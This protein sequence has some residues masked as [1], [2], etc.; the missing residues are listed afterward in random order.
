M[1]LCAKF[2]ISS[3]DSSSFMIFFSIVLVLNEKLFSSLATRSSL[4]KVSK[5]SLFEVPHEGPEVKSRMCRPHPQRDRKRRLNG[6]VCQ[7]HRIKKV[8]PRRC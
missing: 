2:T 4:F 1:A 3:L 8:V 7:N 6:A 5:L